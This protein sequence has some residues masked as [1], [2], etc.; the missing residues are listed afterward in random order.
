[1][2][3]VVGATGTLGRQL[4]PLLV[5]A[6]HQVR[7][8]TRTPARADSLT[9]P[10]VEVVRGDLRD[11]ESLRVAMR[12]VTAVISASHALT[13]SGK[14]SSAQ[15]DDAGQRALIAAARASDVEHFTYISALGASATHPIDF[16][17]TKSRIEEVVRASGMPH[18][19]VRPSAFMDFHAY[20]LIGKAV[21][22]GKRV[23]L[24]GAGDRKRNFVAAADVAR[25]IVRVLAE[26]RHEDLTL[27]ID[28]PEDLSSMEVV[29]IFARVAGREAKVTHLPMGLA[30]WFSRLLRP[31]HEG[32]GRVLQSAVYGETEDEPYM[33]DALLAR[34]PMPL[35]RLEDW[36]R[37]RAATSR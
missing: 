5:E 35:T 3:L 34:F 29:G 30:H 32:V 33:P 1:M 7:A 25:L 14:G 11:P 37:A 15:V 31:L 36:A 18:A 13:G 16:W 17:R 20:E 24:F 2:I 21:L 27:E 23:M 19:I 12:G 8:M 28:G 10:N 9:A 22:R 26:A 6:G 4:V